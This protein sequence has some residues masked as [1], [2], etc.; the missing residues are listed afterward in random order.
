MKTS[1]KHTLICSFIATLCILS[2]TLLA[3]A[4]NN[5]TPTDVTSTNT[6]VE[7]T[8]T[9]TP[10]IDTSNPPSL[11]NF[12]PENPIIHQ[13]NPVDTYQSFT[14]VRDNRKTKIHYKRQRVTF[15][16]GYQ[17]YQYS[18]VK[19]YNSKLKKNA[20]VNDK[21][22][23]GATDGREF[24]PWFTP[25]RGAVGGARRTLQSF[26][27]GKGNDTYVAYG[28]DDLKNYGYIYHYNRKGKLINTSK[29]LPMGHAQSID[30]IDGKLYIGADMTD[31]TMQRIYA[32]NPGTLTIENEWIVPADVALGTMTMRDTHT[33][34][35][36]SK[37]DIDRGYQLTY[38]TLNSDGTTTISDV[39]RYPRTVGTT[40]QRELQFFT[41]HNG[42]YYLQSN[43]KYVRIDETTGDR[44]DVNVDMPREAEGMGFTSSGRMVWAVAQKN[45]F[46]IEK[47]R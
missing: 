35:T 25:H 31:R 45:Q 24:K 38:L 1:Y 19:T 28:T 23:F 43:S 13:T 12:T 5:T 2:P 33:A 44:I 8:P 18:K 3:L 22:A 7:D 6:Q 26:T 40:K 14:S 34:V 32:L 15:A 30:Y 16:D 11:A 29:K 41:Y 37:Y 17:T 20:K 42:A 36:A 47:N 9:D 46:F 21:Y 27:F 10:T 4:T 39:K